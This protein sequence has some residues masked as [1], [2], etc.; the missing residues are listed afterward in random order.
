MSAKEMKLIYD[1]LIASGDLD[2]LFP[3]MTGDWF[4]DKK[5]F[6]I[7]YNSTER[8]LES[9]DEEDI[10]DMDDLDIYEHY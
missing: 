2:V 1:S 7:Q 6:V 4:L 5:E 8:L 3:T 10:D 9:L